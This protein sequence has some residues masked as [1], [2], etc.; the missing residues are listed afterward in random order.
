MTITDT[1]AAPL[2]LTGSA[3]ALVAA[4][5]LHRLPDLYARMHAAT[6]PATLGLTLCATAAIVRID[7]LGAATTLALAIVLQLFTAPTA[8]HL[9]GRAAHGQRAPQSSHTIADELEADADDP[10]NSR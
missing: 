6:K 5:G 4:I 9:L 8:A 10:P 1:I 2:L 3:L 7:D